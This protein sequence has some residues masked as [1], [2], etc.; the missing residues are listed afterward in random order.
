MWFRRFILKLCTCSN[1][2]GS[3]F[4][5]KFHNSSVTPV[6]KTSP[7]WGGKREEAITHYGGVGDNSLYLEGMGEIKKKRSLGLF[8]GDMR[9]AEETVL[10]LQQ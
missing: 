10:H 9:G 5:P 8:A 1:P 2:L 6:N 3:C 4:E 7:V